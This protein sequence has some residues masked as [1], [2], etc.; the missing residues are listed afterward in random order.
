MT[1]HCNGRCPWPNICFE[2]DEPAMIRRI[3]PIR[4]DEPIYLM[5]APPTPIAT[6]MIF[7]ILICLGGCAGGI[8]VIATGIMP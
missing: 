1:C 6:W 4:S 5:T 8:F 2:L 7:A 3:R